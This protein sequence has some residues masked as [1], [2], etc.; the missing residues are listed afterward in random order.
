MPHMSRA[1]DHLYRE[2]EQPTAA[3]DTTCQDFTSKSI[4]KPQNTAQTQEIIFRHLGNYHS[5]RTV[6]EG[7]GV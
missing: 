2:L 7:E 4:P 3:V 5:Q 6:S 1:G